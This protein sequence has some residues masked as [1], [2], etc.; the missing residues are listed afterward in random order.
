MSF[1]GHLTFLV[2]PTR[3]EGATGIEWIEAKDLLN[4]RQGTRYPPTTKNFLV[5]NVNRTEAEKPFQLNS[6][7]VFDFPEQPFPFQ[8]LASYDFLNV[9]L[10]FLTSYLSY[11]SSVSFPNFL[12]HFIQFLKYQFILSFVALPYFP[13]LLE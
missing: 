9:A 7:A 12:F 10:S 1:Q 2:V 13:L 3:K 4:T 11:S 6:P 8:I 5:Q